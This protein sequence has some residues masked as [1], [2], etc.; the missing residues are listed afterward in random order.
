MEDSTNDDEPDDDELPDDD[1]EPDSDETGEQ[2]KLAT[3]LLV[4]GDMTSRSSVARPVLD[5]AWSSSSS[6]FALELC[7]AL[8]VLEWNAWKAVGL[9]IF[10]KYVPPSLA[11]WN[12][13][14]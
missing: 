6:S 1:D 4:A 3:A 13:F 5:W 12:V 10:T 9:P 8:A 7:G 14:V 2:L 11:L